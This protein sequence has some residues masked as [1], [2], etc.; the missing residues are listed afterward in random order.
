M[1]R[2][3]AMPLAACIL[4][5]GASSEATRY[6]VLPA[7]N[8]TTHPFEHR[9]RCA[10]RLC[11]VFPSHALFPT[12]RCTSFATLRICVRRPVGIAGARGR[13]CFPWI[14][15]RLQRLAEWRG[16]VQH[17]HGRVSDV[18]VALVSSTYSPHKPS[19]RRHHAGSEAVTCWIAIIAR[20]RWLS[21]V[22]AVIS[23]GLFVA[24][25]VF[26]R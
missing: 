19:L 26:P 21:S 3:W 15:L 14:F 17:W 9:S 18:A 12:L 6:N 25:H 16:R 4:V 7:S 10:H 11:T 20:R 5:A 2:R 24:P 1:L 23:T 8:T 22:A 13:D